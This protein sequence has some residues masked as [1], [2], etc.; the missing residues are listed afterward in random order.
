[1]YHHVGG[2]SGVTRFLDSLSF[3]SFDDTTMVFL[4]FLFFRL[5]VSPTFLSCLYSTHSS[6]LSAVWLGPFNVLW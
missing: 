2:F 1:M 4:Y 5:S 3:T 6:C